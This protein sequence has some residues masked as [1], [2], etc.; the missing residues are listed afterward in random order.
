MEKTFNNNNNNSLYNIP[1]HEN[2]IKNMNENNFETIHKKF[3]NFM[4]IPKSNRNDL[5]RNYINNLNNFKTLNFNSFNNNNLHLKFKKKKKN[6]M[7]NKTKDFVLTANCYKSVLSAREYF[8]FND[9]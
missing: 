2:K 8:F 4:E 7:I 3:N 6:H 1:H 9:E 5:K